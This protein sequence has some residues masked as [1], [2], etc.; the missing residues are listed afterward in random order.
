MSGC[1]EVIPT[2]KIHKKPIVVTL[3]SKNKINYDIDV[4]FSSHPTPNEHSRKGAEKIIQYLQESKEQDLVLCLISG[5]GSSL[6]SLPSES[7]PLNDKIIM[8]ELLLASGCTVNEINTIRKHIS[9]IKGGKLAEIAFPSTVRSLI[10][11]DVVN[12][13]ISSIASGPTSPDNTTFQDAADILKKYNLTE[14]VPKTILH[15]INQGILGEITETPNAEEVFL[16]VK[17]SIICS[18][19]IFRKNLADFSKEQRYSHC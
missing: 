8:T 1:L 6:L 9:L 7:I 10:I 16:K 11:S 13:D 5:G 12:D 17:N 18:N 3:E 19:K 14:K 15:N 2:N 4:C